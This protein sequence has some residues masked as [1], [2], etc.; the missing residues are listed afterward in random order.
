MMDESSVCIVFCVLC[1]HLMFNIIIGG[2]TNN[3]QIKKYCVILLS[4][5]FNDVKMPCNVLFEL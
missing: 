1:R 4:A 2:S 3:I 5:I